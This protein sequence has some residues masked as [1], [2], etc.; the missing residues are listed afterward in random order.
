MEREVERC[1][2]REQCFFPPPPSRPVDVPAGA[3]MYLFNS[4]SEDR[5]PYLVEAREA[6]ITRLNHQSHSHVCLIQSAREAL[7]DHS[8]GFRLKEA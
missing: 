8:R 5:P 3:G 1:A 4:Q 6:V 2:S 7:D